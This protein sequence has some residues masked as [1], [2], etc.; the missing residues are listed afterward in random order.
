LHTPP[1]KAADFV[2]SYKEGFLKLSVQ[3]ALNPKKKKKKRILEARSL[4]VTTMRENVI[5]GSVT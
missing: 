3:D 1:F 4:R 5:A 2:L